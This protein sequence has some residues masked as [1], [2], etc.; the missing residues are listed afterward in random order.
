MPNLLSYDDFRKR[1]AEKLW[2]KGFKLSKANEISNKIVER[3]A[4]TSGGGSWVQYFDYGPFRTS[5][6]NT[7]RDFLEF[8]RNTT[9]GVTKGS[10]LRLIKKFRTSGGIEAVNGFIEQKT[11]FDL[12][13]KRLKFESKYSPEDISE[14]GLALK[15]KANVNKVLRKA[16]A[17]LL[18]IKQ[19]IVTVFATPMRVLYNAMTLMWSAMGFVGAGLGLFTDN[20]VLLAVL[21]LGGMGIDSP[22]SVQEIEVAHSNKIVKFRAVGSIFLAFQRGGQHSVRIVGKLTG[23][24][25]LLWLS[26]LWMLT[27]MSKGYME[28]LDWDSEMITNYINNPQ[29]ALAMMRDKAFSGGKLEATEGIITQKPSYEKHITFPVILNHE[30]IPNA[31]IETFSFEETVEGGKDVINYDLLLRTYTEPNE[32][33]ADASH[34]TFY[35]ANTRTKTQAVLYYSANFTYRLLKYKK[36][37]IGI[38]TNSWKVDNYYDVDAVDMGFVFGLALAGAIFE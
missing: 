13:Y 8:M 29:S 24:L 21:P 11:E 27:L 26:I 36:E 35:Y 33:V 32:F 22:T 20:E 23:E 1:I 25:R 9:F 6:Y 37:S 19:K 38:D 5:R 3:V 2:I 10:Y 14:A 30:I 28:V 7:L 16:Q 12:K 17:T 18:E 15:L 34:T 31:Y 4:A